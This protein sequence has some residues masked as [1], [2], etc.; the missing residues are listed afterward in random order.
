MGHVRTRILRF[1]A[2]ASVLAAL[3][4]RV[5]A[6]ETPQPPQLRL[7]D[8]ATPIAYEAQLA[9]DPN[10][11][12]FSGAIRIDLR[13]NR[14]VPVLWLS[15][16]AL[17]IEAAE[18][19]QGTRRIAV[20]A[21][22]GGEDFVGF[23]PEE[24][25]FDAGPAVATIRYRGGIDSVT[26]RGVYRQSEGG[27]W[28]VITQFEAI[29]ARFAFPCFDEP[30]WKT[31]WRLTIDAPTSNVVTSNTPETSDSIVAAMPGWRRHAFATTK[32]LPTYLVAL[33]VGPFD[34]VNAWR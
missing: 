24:G 10:E 31:P 25:S 2:F 17:T 30:G 28:Y 1:T 23:V 13:F 4:G 33:A 7:G 20:K 9:I 29:S 3:A 32:P 16:S 5:E 15:A 6:A 34:V 27:Q 11:S 14:A 21:I 12:S 8:G 19:E 26:K 18:I 22:P